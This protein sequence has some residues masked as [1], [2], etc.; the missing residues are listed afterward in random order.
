M[1]SKC[2][3]IDDEPLAIKVIQKHIDNIDLLEVVGTCNRAADAFT[4]LKTM[5]VDLIFLDIKMPGIS[6]IDLVKTLQ[7]PPAVIFTTA[8]RDYAIEGYELNAIDYLLKP[9]PF[10]RF[11]KAV[12]KY[13][14]Q[15]SVPVSSSTPLENDE[16]HI[17]VKG[18]KKVHKVLLNDIH[19][20]ESLK[21]YVKIV[22]NNKEIVAKYALNTLEENLNTTD[23]IRIHRS[24]IIGIKHISGFS[25]NSIEIHNKELPIG[26]M[27]SKQVFEKL[28]YKLL[29]E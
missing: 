25:A 29:G 16:K 17:F 2:L 24:F 5:E 12:N 10:D 9:I 28:N 3:I 8:Y 23:F 6:G 18:N 27:Y 15:R 14:N 7:H 19:Y 22:T 21:D 4:M 13:I 11:L 26:R 1:I 20:I